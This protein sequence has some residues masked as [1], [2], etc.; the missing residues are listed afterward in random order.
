MKEYRGSWEVTGGTVNVWL[1]SSGE[2]IDDI[3]CTGCEGPL[4][5]K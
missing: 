3:S 4:D 1:S 5:I 2:D